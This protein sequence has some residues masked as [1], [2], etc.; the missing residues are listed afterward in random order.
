MDWYV[1]GF[2]RVRLTFN[3][4]IP[5]RGE[6]IFPV[7]FE[8]LM[9]QEWRVYSENEILVQVKTPCEHWLKLQL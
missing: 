5:T 6:T 8:K 3:E 2:P 9:Y 7:G 1:A 4:G